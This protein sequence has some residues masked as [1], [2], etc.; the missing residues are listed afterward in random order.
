MLSIILHAGVYGQTSQRCNFN[1]NVIESTFQVLNIIQNFGSDVTYPIHCTWTL[2]ASVGNRIAIFLALI[3]ED[4]NYAFEVSKHI[5]K[6]GK[7]I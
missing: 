3:H 5:S 4:R 2:T 1:I 6:G 7:S